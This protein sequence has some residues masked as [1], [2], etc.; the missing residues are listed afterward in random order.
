MAEIVEQVENYGLSKKDRPKAQFAKVGVVGCGS[1]GQNIVRMIST[2]GIEVV[3][4]E[5][6]EERIQ[7]ALEEIEKEFDNMIEHWGMTSGEKRAVMARIKGSVGYE[8]LDGCDL[9]VEAIRSKTREDRV[10]CRKKLFQEIEKHVD[11]H[12]IIATNSTT[13]VITELSSELQH[14]DRCVS[15]HFS[16]TAPHSNLIEV[17]RGLYT[18]E[19]AYDNVKKFVK[20]IGRNIIPVEESPGLISVRLF[21][22]V[23]NEACEM[24]MEGVGSKEDIDFTM[25]HSIGMELGPFEMADKI[26]LDKV[27]RWMD[28]LYSEF[29]DRK[30]KASPIIKKLVRA[31]QTG[32]NAGKGFYEYNNGNNN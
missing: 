4:I 2:K 8:K 11:P 9:V 21:V 16:T 31:K 23:I 19:E 3:F 29:G 5:L 20:L 26:G 25:R 1:V 14:K 27:L 17:V 30:Y 13:I 6:S 7:A 18:S 15:L 12:T 32:R 10:S 24:L 28:N 22:N